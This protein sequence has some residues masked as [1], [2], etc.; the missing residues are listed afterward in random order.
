MIQKIKR[1]E[2][3]TIQNLNG[4]IVIYG[5][6]K[7][8]KT[9]LI[10]N[11]LKYDSYFLIRRDRKIIT[12][13]YDIKEI[14]DI[15]LF[16]EIIKGLLKKNK[17][18]IIDE[19]QRLPEFIF[20]EIAQLHPKR[21]IILSGSSL[22]FIEKFVGIKSSLLGLTL[23]YKLDL[24][25]PLN[26]ITELAKQIS[27]P[28]DVIETSTYF[29]DPWLMPFYKKKNI[30]KLLFEI[31]QHSKFTIPALIGEVFTEEERELTKVYE[32]IIS[33]LG[34]GK[35][36]YT[37]IGSLLYNRGLI[38]QPS[39]AF[40][41]PYIKNLQ[42][43]NLIYALQL[44]NKKKKLYKLSSPIIEMYY[45]LQDRYNLNDRELTFNEAEPTINKL[46]QL[47]IQDF[48]AQLFA[49]KNMGK[50]EY[51][52]EK[53]KEID[54]IIT[55]RNKSKIIGEVK[56]GNYSKKDIDSFMLKTEDIDG[57]R[58]FIVKKKSIDD[59]RLKILD[60]SDIIKMSKQDQ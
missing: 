46:I 26:I 60:A 7:V 16:K 32:G 29:R 36:D 38:P 31:I 39:S 4:W 48:I 10:K 11:F 3:K 55:K 33:S 42:K 2:A 21:K 24:I 25:Q 28:I 50:R 34:S 17:T 43:M 13:K 23:Q 9:F 18:V 12:E 37:L 15:N 5:R 57:N 35:W 54:F 52:V 40:V 53:D 27:N 51:Y 41:L 20:E 14:N 47:S 59:N 56:W 1:Y 8:G 22:R 58:R 30:S 45:Y 49:Q 44:Y 19:F 6:R